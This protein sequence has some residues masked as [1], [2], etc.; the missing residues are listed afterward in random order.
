MSS[1]QN[2]CEVMIS[3]GLTLFLILSHSKP[4]QYFGLF[5]YIML[6]PKYLLIPTIWYTPQSFK[7]LS[8]LPIHGNSPMGFPKGILLRF[9][10]WMGCWGLLG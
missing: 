9:T 2:L 5:C 4:S 7:R 3:P 6:H 8:Q 1:V 10:Q